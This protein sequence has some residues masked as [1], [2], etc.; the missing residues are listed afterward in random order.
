M[1]N[2]YGKAVT[3]VIVTL[4]G[5]HEQVRVHKMCFHDA[6]EYRHGEKIT[7]QPTNETFILGR[8]INSTRKTTK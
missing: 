7:A 8:A 2:P 1:T 3:G 5:D 6:S 4:P